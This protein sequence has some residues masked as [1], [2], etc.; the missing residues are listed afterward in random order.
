MPYL[1]LLG[2]SIL[3]NDPYVGREPNTTELLQRTLGGAWTVELLARDGATMADLRFQVSRLPPVVDA[4][5]LS[6]GGNDAIEHVGLIQPRSVTSDRFLAELLSLADDFTA[7]YESV[8]S[9]VRPRVTRLVVC[10]IYEP[11]L[12]DPGLARLALVP[13]GLLNDRIVRAAGRHH[14]DVIELRAVC[15]DPSDFV[16]EIEPS[17]GGARKIAEAI[18]RAVQEAGDP[19]TKFFAG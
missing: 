14:S 11:P 8:L 16:R 15:T 6:V 12:T 18:T 4:A 10:T 2:D 19:A 3:D 13:L 17:P 1:G 9:L 7:A 5:V